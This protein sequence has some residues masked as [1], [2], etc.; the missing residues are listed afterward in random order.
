MAD[1]KIATDALANTEALRRIAWSKQIT[2][3]SLL[4]DPMLNIPT[5]TG[6]IDPGVSTKMVP[7]KVI[8]DVTPEGDGKYSRSVVLEYIQALNGTGYYGSDVDSILS[9]EENIRVKYFKAYSNDWATAVAGAKFGIVFREQEPSKVFSHAKPLLAQWWGEREGSFV[10][11]AYCQSVSEN[12]TVAPVSQLPQLNA[13]TYVVDSA[14]PLLQISGYD[15]YALYAQAV[16][17]SLETITGSVESGTGFLNVRKLMDLADAAANS[18]IRPISFNGKDLYILYVAP[19]EFTNLIDPAIAA[20]FGA[21]WVAAAAVQDLN[22][23]IPGAEFVVADTI[24]VCRDR[25]CPTAYI[26]NTGASTDVTFNY[27]KM[28]RN[29]ER[30][31]VVANSV[32]FNAN[33]LVGESALVKFHSEP[34]HYEDEDYMYTKYNNVGFFG[35]C[36]YQVPVFTNSD[37]TADPDFA[38]S[39]QESSI[40]VFTWKSGVMA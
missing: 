6:Q 30:K 8:Q 15:T 13:N 14:T 10:R 31:T 11:Q 24:V 1:P 26:L 12:L 4:A 33:I 37:D 32:V 5:L 18:Y 28:G 35:A 27:V 3:E 39:T 25:R 2:M 36:G 17:T 23:V 38:N 34:P 9:N 40:V 22:K 19:S 7:G 29:D 21:N 16:V 20:S